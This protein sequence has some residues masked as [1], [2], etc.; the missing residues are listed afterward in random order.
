[1][2]KVL[3]DC[4]NAPQDQ[5][6]IIQNMQAWTNDHM[7]NKTGVSNEDLDR[8]IIKFNLKENEKFK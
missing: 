3:E 7:F 5:L 4:K 6:L 8:A 2:P 1:M